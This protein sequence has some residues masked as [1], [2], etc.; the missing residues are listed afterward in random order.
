MTY[1]HTME[2]YVAA[3]YDAGKEYHNYWKIITKCY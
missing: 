2:N 1:T 3:E